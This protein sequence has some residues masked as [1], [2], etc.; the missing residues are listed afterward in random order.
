MNDNDKASSP[1]TSGG[2]GGGA[3]IATLGFCD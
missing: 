3:D 2:G 1:A